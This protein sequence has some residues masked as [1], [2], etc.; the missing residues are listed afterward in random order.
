MKSIPWVAGFFFIFGLAAYLFFSWYMP[1]S[2]FSDYK[3]LVL[4]TA[5]IGA[6]IGMVIANRQS[7]SSASQPPAEAAK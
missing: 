2:P 4:G 6:I 7:K 1:L 5:V 3:Y